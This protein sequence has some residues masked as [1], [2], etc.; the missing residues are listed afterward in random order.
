M[1]CRWKSGRPCAI[2]G[3]SIPG[4]L[5]EG[6][7]ERV[8]APGDGLPLQSAEVLGR[9]S[10]AVG[11]PGALPDLIGLAW[12]MPPDRNALTPWDVLMV[13][14]GS[15]LFTRCTLRPTLSWTGTTHPPRTHRVSSVRPSSSGA[16]DVGSLLQAV[17]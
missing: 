13:S 16:P 11:I 5:A 8:A 6:H 4:V 1:L 17:R 7:L 15:G 2:A 10:K 14:A 3:C 12:R 9:V